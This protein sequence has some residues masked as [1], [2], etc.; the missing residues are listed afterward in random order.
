MPNIARKKTGVQGRLFLGAGGAGSGRYQ[1]ALDL[2]S[3]GL[4]AVIDNRDIAVTFL[5]PV[6]RATIYAR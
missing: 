2:V 6:T 1:F 4:K 5:A 3:F